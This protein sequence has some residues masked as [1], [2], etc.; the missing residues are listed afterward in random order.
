MSVRLTASTAASSSSRVRYWFKYSQSRPTASM[1]RLVRSLPRT[2]RA[3]Q[4]VRA[5]R[6]PT[7]VTMR[8][9]TIPPAAML[10]DEAH[11]LVPVKVPRG[12]GDDVAGGVA[13][14]EVVEHLVA[15]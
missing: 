3:A 8:R 7:S 14:A 4:R 10:A 6:H 2:S 9:C 1:R 11:Q 5:I 13:A 12:D 15:R